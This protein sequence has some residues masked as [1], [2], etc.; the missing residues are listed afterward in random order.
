MADRVTGEVVLEEPLGRHQVLRRV[1]GRLQPQPLREEVVVAEPDPPLVERD[2]EEVQAFELLEQVLRV[3]D[4]SD[5][6]AEGR[7]QALEV[8]GGEEEGP[9]AFG[10]PRQHLVAEVVGDVPVVAGE[11]V[12]HARR[13]LVTAQGQPHELHRR[14]PAVGPVLE[15]SEILF[16]Q[17]Q[18][19]DLVQHHTDLSRIEPEVLEAQLSQGPLRS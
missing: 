3:V 17:R 18:A 8:S 5:S 7:S 10:Q 19:G 4:V 1:G 15:P 9:E 12:D 6:C 16:G 14:G 2:D 11:G 13:V